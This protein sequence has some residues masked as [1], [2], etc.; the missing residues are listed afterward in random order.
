MKGKIRNIV[1]KH[2]LSIYK[3][4]TNSQLHKTLKSIQGLEV[5][6]NAWG[7]GFKPHCTRTQIKKRYLKLSSQPSANLKMVALN[8]AQ[9]T[10]DRGAWL[11]TLPS[12]MQ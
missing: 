2:K 5:Y 10:E 6:L 8:A 11:D 7:S 12:V 9:R 1:Q 3:R 4:N